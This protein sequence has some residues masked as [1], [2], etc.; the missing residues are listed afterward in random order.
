M[1][2]FT[3]TPY[4]LISHLLVFGK[5]S[6]KDGAKNMGEMHIQK[7]LQP[8][9]LGLWPPPS[10]IRTQMHMHVKNLLPTFFPYVNADKVAL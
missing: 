2:F 1:V 10:G 4:F 9:A 8:S 7:S 6:S 3:S 5:C